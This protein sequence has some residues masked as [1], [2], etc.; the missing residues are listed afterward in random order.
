MPRILPATPAPPKLDE[1]VN[2]W[3]VRY[4]EAVSQRRA[5]EILGR[6]PMT[7]NRWVAD[8]TLP[9]TPDKSVLVRPMAE[10]AYRDYCNSRSTRRR[11][12][13]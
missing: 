13:L 9:H 11:I 6:S 2:D 3:I 5:A 4:G 7:I 8:G 10:W 12:A 1:I